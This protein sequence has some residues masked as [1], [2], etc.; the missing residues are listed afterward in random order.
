VARLALL[1]A[2]CA[3]ALAAPGLA[4]AQLV[5]TVSDPGI[6]SLT[7]NGAPVTHLVP[8]TYTIEVHDTTPSHNFHLT[9]P[10]VSETTGISDEEAPTWTVTF[11]HGVY[12]FQCDVH[13]DSMFG[14]FTVGNVLEVDKTGTGLGTVTST[15]AGID[16]GGTCA[17]AYPGGGMV[18]LT[19]SATPG[20]TF[21]GWGGA[22]TGAGACEVTVSGA[23]S[24]TATFTLNSG[25]G[26]PTGTGP[27]AKV[28][29]VSVAKKKGVRTVT[30]ALDASR[31]LSVQTRITRATKAIVSSKRSFAAG[32]RTVT[33]KIPKKTK[34]GNATVTITL[35]GTT[36]STQSYKITRTVKLPKP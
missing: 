35:K 18:A 14:N 8:G 3:V 27:P 21:T 16:C 30:V 31:A 15:P 5:A 29:K 32:K 36:G 4:Q 17:F 20:S 26:P 25:P 9:G 24:V 19:A 28:T 33:L 12:H 23:V 22:C 13:P 7:Q 10:G 2:V 11:T 1:S 6:I 34:G